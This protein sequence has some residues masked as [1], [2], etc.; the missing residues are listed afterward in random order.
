MKNKSLLPVLLLAAF[1]LGACNLGGQSSQESKEQEQ[2]ASS[3]VQPTTSEDTTQYGVQIANKA[4]LQE[5]F[6]AGD[7]R[8]LDITLTPAANPLAELGKNL[9]IVSSD[10]EVV[11]VTGLG[12][13]ALKVGTATI[14]VKYHN[15]Q[16]TV[17]LTI[18]ENSAKGRYGVAHAG[19][20]D[21]PFTNEEALIVAKS[22]K[23]ADD[24]GDYYVKGVVASFYH[25]AGVKKGESYVYARSD[26]A[27]S[28]FLEPAQAGGEKFEIYKCYK[29]GTKEASYLTDDDIWVGG[30]AIA[31]G[32]FTSYNGQYETTSA[33]F[34]SCSGNKPAA[35]AVV[36]K[37]FAEVLTI[38]AGLADGADSWD[39]L[40]FTGFV[41]KKS[42]TDFYLTA[43][44]GEAL[45]SGKSDAAH[46]TK[47]VYTNAIELFG[48]G[49][50]DAL[51]TKLLDGAEVEVTMI[52]KNY[53]GTAENLLAL[54]DG[55]VTVVTAGTPWAVPEPEV[56]NRTLK[57]FI[58][59][60]NTKAKAYIVKGTIK[61]WGGATS[62]KGK[63]GN[64]TLTD[65]T[66]D[67]IIYGSSATATALAWDNSEAYAFTNPQDFLTNE[68]TAS[69]AI[70]N[71][72]TMKLIRCDFTDTAAGTTKIEGT[73]IITEVTPIEATAIA[74]DKN[75]AE[76]EVEGKVTLKAT[77]TPANSNSK[78]TWRSSDDTIATVENGV[79]TGVAA[80]TATITAKVSDEIKAECVVTVKAAAANVE[81]ITIDLTKKDYSIAKADP[82]QTETAIAT[83]AGI[84]FNYMNVNNSA[85]ASAYLFFAS[86]NNSGNTLLSNHTPVPGAITKVE[87]TTTDGA[88]GSAQYNVAFGTS[89]IKAKITDETNK[90]VGKGTF[91]FTANSEANYQYVGI[92]SVLNGYNGQIAKIEITYV[93]SA[94]PQPEV[95]QP[96]GAYRGYAVVAGAE[97]DTNMF[98]YIALGANN[99][100]YVEIKDAASGWTKVTVDYTFDKT[101]GL[102]TIP[103]G[104]N[105]G[106]LVGTFDDANNTLKNCSASGAAAAALKNNGTM[107]FAPVTYF[108]DC[109]GTSEQLNAIFGRR[110]RTTSPDAWTATL[111]DV[112]ADTT[113]FVSGATGVSRAGS[114]D[115]KAV[116]LTLRNDFATAVQLESIGFWVYNPSNVDITLRTWVFASKSY[117]GAA[118]IG[119]LTA[120]ANGWTYCRMGFT[121]G[122]YYNVNICDW[123][124]GGATLTFDDI[125]LF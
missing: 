22:P 78:V 3:E 59:G 62:S 56:A 69:L 112:A 55:D 114:T 32:T 105:Y 72:I 88:S 63:Y 14:T 123:T 40:K 93:P 73:G 48:A 91:S 96:N 66:N 9:T 124:K 5:E 20:A 51:N 70:G 102:V 60:E 87:F 50:V 27:C 31:H 38:N 121:K 45:V 10:A 13:S 86:K 49:K 122:N 79:V 104:G 16:D 101:T 18:L 115:D 1:A 46:G 76:I 103:V 111:D 41:A 94:A 54:E 58:D 23:Y 2:P 36:S 15:E 65:G 57:E 42:G 4:A 106:N 118:E 125:C 90:Y 34:V 77:L 17:E 68:V 28:Y 74:L 83:I 85:G 109:E 7:N 89:E 25:A 35:R 24:G 117:G 39:F 120:K 19:T 71:E 97:G 8:D 67:L 30:E 53:H 119:Q 113:N 108:M 110:V 75:T 47:D 100:A 80:G 21:D 29:D 11:K 43:T 84:E 82:V 92:S 61:D 33:K 44:K 26:G 107:E 116:G 99:K 6:Y 52:V 64:M 81:K 37:T 95:A 98:V 12:L